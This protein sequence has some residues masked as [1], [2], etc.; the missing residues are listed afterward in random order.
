V[1]S[2]TARDVIVPATWQLENAGFKILGLIH[3]EIWGSSHP[4]RDEEFKRLMCINPS[5]CDM[6][7]NS[8]LK[9]GVRYLK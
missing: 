8:D 2:A 7:I 5:W 1:V 9:V 6:S 3:D 4:G